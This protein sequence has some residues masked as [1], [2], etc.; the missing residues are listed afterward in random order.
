MEI[1]EEIVR[2]PLVVLTGAGASAPLDKL[3]TEA[4]L[5][6]L[7]DKARQ[8]N[9]RD[10]E[11]GAL[12]L[13][14]T[15]KALGLSL[16]VEDVLATLEQ[17]IAALDLLINDTDFGRAVLLGGNTQAVSYRSQHIAVRDFIYDAVIDHYGA[18]NALAAGRLYNVLFRHL[19]QW[20][21]P[22]LGQPVRTS[23]FSHSTT[24]RQL[25]PPA[26]SST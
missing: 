1:A 19:D 9:Q 5:R 18:I 7:F 25:R 20:L 6:R 8:L 11:M 2:S 4:F 13:E 14:T 26:P 10:S 21:Q 16:D 24:T 22:I 23:P 17:R 3:T 15:G 12:L